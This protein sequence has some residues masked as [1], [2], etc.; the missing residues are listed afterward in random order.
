MRRGW[1]G[2]A[3]PVRPSGCRPRCARLPSLLPEQARPHLLPGAIQ[4]SFGPSKSVCNQ[5]K[6]PNVSSLLL[7]AVHDLQCKGDDY[8]GAGRSCGGVILSRAGWL[9]AARVPRVRQAAAQVGAALI[10]VR[11]PG[12]VRRLVQE[13]A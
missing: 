6:L 9:L 5:L 4:T 7:S 12:P 11:G 13:G 1:G 2:S 10:L 3:S 8:L